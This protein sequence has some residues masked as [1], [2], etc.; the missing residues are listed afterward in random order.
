[1]HFLLGCLFNGVWLLGF[2]V[3]FYLFYR[4]LSEAPL[5]EWLRFAVTLALSIPGGLIGMAGFIQLLCLPT[6]WRDFVIDDKLRALFHIWAIILGACA[7][8]VGLYLLLRPLRLQLEL[9]QIAV[10]IGGLA[11]WFGMMEV[12]ER[13]VRRG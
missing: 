4:I 6:S 8:A 3:L 11:F 1:M 5:P 7:V 9:Q 13:R 2:A 10:G 12:M